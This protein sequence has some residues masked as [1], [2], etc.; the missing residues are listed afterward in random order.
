MFVYLNTSKMKWIIC[1][2]DL[3]NLQT[4]RW[5]IKRLASG[6]K[7]SFC[8]CKNQKYLQIWLIPRFPIIPQKCIIYRSLINQKRLKLV[9]GYLHYKA[10]SQNVSSEAQVNNFFIFF[11]RK[12][13]FRSQDF[14]IFV[15]LTSPWFI[16]SATS[17]WVL[18]HET[19]CISKYICWTKTH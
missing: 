18:V 14:Q 8:Q 1:R 16:K 5:K 4:K 17:W 3:Y 10:T 6:C 7:G 2:P 19:G 13:M 15:F 12:V 9:K 11:F